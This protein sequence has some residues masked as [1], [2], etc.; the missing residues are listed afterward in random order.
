MR[1]QSV[2]GGQNQQGEK[3]QNQIQDDKRDGKN[4]VKI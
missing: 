2:F 3:I 1:N 4:Q